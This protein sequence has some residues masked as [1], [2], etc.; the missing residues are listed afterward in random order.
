MIIF[1]DLTRVQKPT[2][3]S[4]VDYAVNVFVNRFTYIRPWLHVKYKKKTFL[5]F[6]ERPA[7]KIAAWN[8]C[9]SVNNFTCNYV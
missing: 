2:E 4:S 5:A 1:S 6:V 7:Q 3:V 9:E 8:A